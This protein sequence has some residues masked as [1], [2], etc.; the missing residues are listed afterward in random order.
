LSGTGPD[1]RHTGPEHFSEL[2]D[3]KTP[4]GRIPKCKSCGEPSQ[5]AQIIEMLPGS[6]SGSTVQKVTFYCADCHPDPFSIMSI[7][8]YPQ[9]ESTEVAGGDYILRKLPR[10]Q[11]IA[12]VKASRVR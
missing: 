12:R 2:S 4:P 9:Y 11:Q 6:L 1:A 3:L 10:E 7:A 5:G 8:L